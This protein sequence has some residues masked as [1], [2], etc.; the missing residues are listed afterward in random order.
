MVSDSYGVKNGAMSAGPRKKPKAPSRRWLLYIVKCG[1]ETFY[2][3]ITND[4]VRRLEMHNA[5]RASRYTRSRLPVV[6]VYH[7]RCK[8]KSS[9]LKKE[10]EIKSLSR[11]E[12]EGY[13]ASKTRRSIRPRKRRGGAKA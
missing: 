9:A 1:D 4:L 7:E 12:K 3:G 10:Y 11:T 2:T 6:L 13:I 5:G 8:D